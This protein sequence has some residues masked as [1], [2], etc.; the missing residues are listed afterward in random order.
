MGLF[1]D[2][3]QSSMRRNKAEVDKI[4][5]KHKDAQDIKDVGLLDLG[6]AMYHQQRYDKLEKLGIIEDMHKDG[7]LQELQQFAKNGGKPTGF[8]ADF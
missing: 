5:E 6:K 3:R 1:S 8:G 7:S 2:M 4:E